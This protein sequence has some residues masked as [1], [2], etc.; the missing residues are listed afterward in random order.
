MITEIALELFAV[1]WNQMQNQTTPIIHLRIL[2]WLET[3]WNNA[4]TRLLLMAFRSCGKSTLVGIFAAWLLYRNPNLRIMVLAADS[5]L[6]KKMVRNV[7]R[8]LERHPLTTHLKPQKLD[9]WAGDRFTINR[10]QELRDPSMIARGI[11]SNITGSRADI[12][13]YD[14]VE[15]PNTCLT[16]EKRQDL[17]TRL[18]ESTFILAAGGMQLYV[19]TPHTYDTIYAVENDAQKA[20]QSDAFLDNFKDLRVPILNDSGESVWPE[21]FSCADIDALKRQVGPNRFASQMMLQPVNIAEGRL[22]PSQLNFYNHAL[23]YSEA[24]QKPILK[25]NGK[26][27]VSCSAWWDPSFGSA[28]GD[29]SVLAIIFTDDDGHYY[30]HHLSY[31][32]TN[33]NDKDDEATQQCK[34]I[35]NICAR[36]Y[37]PSV[38]VEINGIGRFLPAILKREMRGRGYHCAVVEKSSRIPKSQRILEGFDAVLAARALSVHADIKATPFLTEMREWRPTSVNAKDDGLDAVAGALS[39]EPIRIGTAGGIMSKRHNWQGSGS[40]FHIKK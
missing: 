13:I 12:I 5:V 25:L 9:Q 6:A 11:S 24:Q 22:N 32:H 19:G 1:V 4:D 28:S 39:Q 36:F 17:R 8:I 14:D 16:M 20:D 23:D 38:S 3:S 37:V 34:Q 40:I 2:R 7:K 27:L 26:R 33:A 18:S 29:A 10:T 15:V 35:A 31:I 21:R 30:L